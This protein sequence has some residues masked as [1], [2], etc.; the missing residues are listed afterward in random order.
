ME[1]SEPAF[2]GDREQITD[3]LLQLHGGNSEAIDRVLPL[4]YDELRRMAHQQ[5]QGERPG[6]TLGITGLV[7][8]TYLKLVNQT[9]VEWRDRGHFFRVASWAMRRI[10][11]DYARRYRA[12]RRGGGL[13]WVSLEEDVAVAARGETLL[14]LDEAHALFAEHSFRRR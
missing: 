4:V 13:H 14:A 2:D 3:L 8:E 11:V 7:H 12:L 9:R 10:L 6:H 1:G 5:L